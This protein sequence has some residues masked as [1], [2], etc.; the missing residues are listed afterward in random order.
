MNVFNRSGPCAPIHLVI[1]LHGSGVLSNLGICDG[2]R[3]RALGRMREAA[4]S[5][6]ETHKRRFIKLATRLHFDPNTFSQLK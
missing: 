6:T 4:V 2:C 5:A 1:P 3:R